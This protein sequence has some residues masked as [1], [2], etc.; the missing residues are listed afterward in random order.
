M[1]IAEYFT[2]SKADRIAHPFTKGV[3]I[4]SE[5]RTGTTKQE[6]GKVYVAG[7]REALEEANKSNARPWNF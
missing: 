2:I 7:K 4:F 3:V 5:M 6:I 1:L